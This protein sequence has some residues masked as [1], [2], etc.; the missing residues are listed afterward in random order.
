MLFSAAS[1]DKGL[2]LLHISRECLS[3]ASSLLEPYSEGLY[4]LCVVPGLYLPWRAEWRMADGDSKFTTIW[5]K[6]LCIPGSSLCA[7]ILFY[8]FLT[9]S[10]RIKNSKCTC[11]KEPDT[12]KGLL[13]FPEPN[14]ITMA[15]M[16]PKLRFFWYLCHSFHDIKN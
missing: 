9:T 6:S 11:F 8:M 7:H 15:E 2:F 13:T 5:H 4:E 16:G 12:Q 1:R 14:S 10:P 3:L